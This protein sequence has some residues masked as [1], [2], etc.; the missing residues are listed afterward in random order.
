MA[1]FLGDRE[2]LKPAVRDRAATR[3]TG[4]DAPACV[5]DGQG[6]G[7]GGIRPRRRVVAASP[8]VL[9][10][11]TCRLDCPVS[12]YPLYS[13]IYSRP[14]VAL[15]PGIPQRPGHDP[16]LAAV[17]ERWD[18]IAVHS[19]EF[20]VSSRRVPSAP[21]SPLA[22]C[23]DLDCPGDLPRAAKQS[24]L[25]S[26]RGDRNTEPEA[27]PLH[28][29]Y[30]A[31]QAPVVP[32]CTRGRAHRSSIY[33]QTTT[34]QSAEGMPLDWGLYSILRCR[35]LTTGNCI[36]GTWSMDCMIPNGRQDGY[37]NHPWVLYGEL[38]RGSCPVRTRSG[39]GFIESNPRIPGLRPNCT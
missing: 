39:P 3:P 9:A 12:V 14:I 1:K 38:L 15:Q 16:A 7:I 8:S 20:Y 4:P 32:E 2:P 5:S 10:P 13:R 17:R 28:D 18:A 36:S 34:G 6:L 25:A 31:G 23:D 21:H 22:C 11:R 37:E 33:G 24:I 30:L 35:G 29:T 19:L 26:S 27:D